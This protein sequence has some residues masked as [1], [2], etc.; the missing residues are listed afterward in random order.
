MV[1]LI[2]MRE[3]RNRSREIMHHAWSEWMRLYF[4]MGK[5]LAFQLNRKCAY[6]RCHNC[7]SW[8][9]V[10][11]T[12]YASIKRKW[13]RVCAEHLFMLMLYTA[14]YERRHR[15][16]LAWSSAVEWSRTPLT[17]AHHTWHLNLVHR[18]HS[19]AFPLHCSLNFHIVNFH[20]CHIYKE[21]VDRPCSA[22]VSCEANHID[23]WFY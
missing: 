3:F 22:K 2:S 16:S 6:D 9:Q 20:V 15:R 19:A 10:Q 1:Y 11:V 13:W 12:V 23:V 5:C 18:F 4:L 14:Q 7:I 8:F 21:F 17:F